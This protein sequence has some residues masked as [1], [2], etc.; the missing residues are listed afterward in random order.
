MNVRFHSKSG[1]YATN[2]LCN[3]LRMYRL[4]LCDVLFMM[5]GHIFTEMHLAFDSFATPIPINHVIY[6]QTI[7]DCFGDFW[8]PC[9][10]IFDG[11]ISWERLYRHILWLC[12]ARDF[13]NGAQNDFSHL[14]RI[15]THIF[16]KPLRAS[17]RTFLILAEA[18][19]IIQNCKSCLKWYYC[20][21]MYIIAL[22][23]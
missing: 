3:H 18:Y 1:R 13:G 8:W 5:S 23:M 15:E 2:I 20:I 11:S 7:S 10:N 17:M 14:G 12:L 22:I 4:L 19:W 9:D 21:L 6:F 16:V